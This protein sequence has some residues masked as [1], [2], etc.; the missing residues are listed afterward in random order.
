MYF[1]FRKD[2]ESNR[3]TSGILQLSDNT[4]LFI[5]ETKLAAGQL[6]PA[7]R[8]NYQ[9]ISDLIVTQ[10]VNYD[11]KFY[12]MQYDTDIPILILSESKSFIPVSIKIK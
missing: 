7:G 4:H 12:P 10:K 9:A 1:F 5:D 11:F 8:Q 2:Y 6:S 3:L